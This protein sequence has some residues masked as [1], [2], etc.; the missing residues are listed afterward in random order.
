MGGVIVKLLGMIVLGLLSAILSYYNK[1]YYVRVFDDILDRTSDGTVSARVGRGFIYGFFF[2]IYFAL[3]FGGLVSLIAFVIVA[4][5]IAAVIFVIVFVSEKILP[6]EWL[7]D[8][9]Q[10]LFRPIGICGPRQGAGCSSASFTPMESNI[11]RQHKL[12]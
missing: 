7:G 1:N 6:H 3:L 4:G 10:S 2:P 9:C 8:I 11:N 5:I 12:D